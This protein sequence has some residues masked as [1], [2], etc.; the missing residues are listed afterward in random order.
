MS[1]MEAKNQHCYKYADTNHPGPNMAQSRVNIKAVT[2]TF[3]WPSA[4]GNYMG[5]DIVSA[6]LLFWLSLHKKYLKFSFNKELSN[7]RKGKNEF[8]VKDSAQDKFVL[9]NTKTPETLSG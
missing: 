6:K 4:F 3:P 5:Q 2:H 8:D 9:W 1:G 7:I